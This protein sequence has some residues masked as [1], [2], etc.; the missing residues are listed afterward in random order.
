MHKYLADIAGAKFGHW[1]GVNEWS[2]ANACRHVSTVE[3]SASRRYKIKTLFGEG[4]CESVT[5]LT[6][7]RRIVACLQAPPPAG[8]CA[9]PRGHPRAQGFRPD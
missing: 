5:F 9:G 2:A 3:I 6:F 7:F 1:C 8:T 4:W